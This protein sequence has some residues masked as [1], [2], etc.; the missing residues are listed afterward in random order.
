MVLA[1]HIPEIERITVRRCS[2]RLSQFRFGALDDPFASLAEGGGCGGATDGGSSCR[3]GSYTPSVL[4]IARTAPSR[5][6]PFFAPTP[7][8][9]VG[10]RLAPAFSCLPLSGEVAFTAGKTPEG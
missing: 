8:D 9:S 4:A 7:L 10:R 2:L 6:E 5:R 1:H 3:G